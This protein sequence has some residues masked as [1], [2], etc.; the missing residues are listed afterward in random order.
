[1][2]TIDLSSI[3]LV[4]NHCHGIYAAQRYTDP[5]TWRG[6]FTESRDVAMRAEHA[7]S[8]LFYRRLLRE[9][10]AFFGCPPVEEAV[11]AARGSREGNEL[12]GALLHA[13]NIEAL[14]IDQGYPPREL[15]LPDAEVGRLA[16]CRMAPMLRVELLMQDLIAA[17]ATLDTVEEAL[18]HALADVRGAGYV[19]LK[20]IA[21][22]RTGLDIRAWERDAAEKA[23]AEARSE[24]AVM[25]A[26]R[27][28]Y[29]PLLDTLLHVVF[30]EAARQEVP[31]QFHVGYGDADADLR[32]ANPLHLRSVLEAL[33]YRGMPVV[34]LHACYPYTREGAYLAAIHERAYLDLSYGIPFLGHGEQLAF[35]RAALGVGPVSKLL[36]SSDGVGLPELHWMGAMTARRV[37]GEALGECVAGGELS[38]DEAEVAGRAVLR[39][40]AVRLYRL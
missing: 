10:A 21:A 35:T 26:V 8:T 14:L 17:H 29:K 20:S 5:A 12:I 39:E 13:A 27:L 1:M 4:D 23:L 7:A 16:G 6:H 36:A 18:R 32:L 11:L 24:V 40:N 34:L 3:P 22:Y 33:E 37:L 9:L 2:P 25:G 15:L 30:A 31:V 19:A 28:G 38:A